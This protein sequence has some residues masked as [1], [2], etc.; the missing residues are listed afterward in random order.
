[1]SKIRRRKINHLIKREI[2]NII[3]SEVYDPR[4]K[5]ITV[6]R[7]DLSEDMHT[8]TIYYTILDELCN[9]NFEKIL[10]K[11]KVFIRYKLARMSKI[12]RVPKIEFI[13]DDLLID[14]SRLI[15]LIDDFNK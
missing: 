11:G 5:N 13:H 1:M 3:S 2:S 7:V 9:E 14:T 4:L 8:A 12:R 6:T 15:K 10:E